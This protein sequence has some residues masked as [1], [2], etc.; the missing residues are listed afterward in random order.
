MQSGWTHSDLMLGVVGGEGAA[1]DGLA[2]LRPLL[3]LRQ[4]YPHSRKLRRLWCSAGQSEVYMLAVGRVGHGPAMHRSAC[5]AH[6][7]RSDTPHLA[8]CFLIM[9]R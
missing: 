1:E 2:D 5:I 3:R 6:G 8:D 4:L 7:A 9:G